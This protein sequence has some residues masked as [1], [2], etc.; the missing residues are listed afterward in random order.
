MGDSVET[1]TARR[2]HVRGEILRSAFVAMLGCAVALASA[3]ATAGVRVGAPD[4]DPGSS[5]G[6]FYRGPAMFVT[7]LGGMQ[8]FR[9]RDQSTV[10]EEPLAE[11]SYSAVGLFE[12]GNADA[13]TAT[14]GAAPKEVRFQTRFMEVRATGLGAATSKAGAPAVESAEASEATADLPL[15]TTVDADAL[16]RRMTTYLGAAV[17][18]QADVQQ[19]VL[20]ASPS[21]IAYITDPS[22]SGQITAA[23]LAGA[24][25]S[26]QL[27]PK[28]GQAQARRRAAAVAVE[29]PK[30]TVDP[31]DTPARLVPEPTS[32]AIWSVLALLVLAGRGF[33]AIAKSGR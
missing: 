30:Q 21:P 9:F 1:V 16:Q 33:L 20:A 25:S 10:G 12:A 11:F 14:S 6:T 8:R 15:I 3:M 19:M 13:A 26:A 28:L 32:I 22:Q 29:T 4:Q 23:M 7:G 31:L 2:F 27:F 5:A 17:Y 18:G 24:A